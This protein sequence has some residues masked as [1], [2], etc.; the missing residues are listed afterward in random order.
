MGFIFYE[1]RNPG[2]LINTEPLRYF[3]WAS[4]FF[5]NRKILLFKKLFKLH[6]ISL[7]LKIEWNFFHKKCWHFGRR[8]C[9]V[10]QLVCMLNSVNVKNWT[11]LFFMLGHNNICPYWLII[12][13]AL[14]MNEQKLHCIILWENKKELKTKLEDNRSILWILF[15]CTRS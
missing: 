11:S 9:I 5:R 10:F 2:F 14:C 1:Q 15:V 3:N 6:Y 8:T 12:A 13:N 4:R 7:F